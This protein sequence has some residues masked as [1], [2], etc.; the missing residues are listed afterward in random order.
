MSHTISSA[1]ATALGEKVILKPDASFSGSPLALGPPQINNWSVTG[2]P[3][4][5]LGLSPSLFSSPGR[6]PPDQI[7]GDGTE[8]LTQGELP[9][10]D[11]T[12]G[13]FRK[14]TAITYQVR[15]P[16]L[17]RAGCPGVDPTRALAQEARGFMG[18]RPR[19][20]PVRGRLQEP[21]SGT[22]TLCSAWSC[23]RGAG[24]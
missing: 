15:C 6:L 22:H 23:P 11:P 8:F 2:H 16:G 18:K 5:I 20:G 21:A 13:P 9:G 24:L 14:H 19:T 12:L 3:S 4:E 7:R 1:P 17:G 10:P